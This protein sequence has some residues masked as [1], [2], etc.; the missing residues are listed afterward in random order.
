MT[1]RGEGG[2]FSEFKQK[3]VGRAGIGMSRGRRVVLK[4]M[5][6]YLKCQ[7][8]VHHHNVDTIA[9]YWLV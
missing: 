3:Q 6:Q 7:Y 8:R 4:I 9:K 5:K 2:T 1:P